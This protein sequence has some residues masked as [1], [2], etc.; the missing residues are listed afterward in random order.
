MYKVTSRI[1][2]ALRSPSGFRLEIRGGQGSSDRRWGMGNWGLPSSHPGDEEGMES[3]PS[4]QATASHRG[5][6]AG[7]GKS[8]QGTLKAIAF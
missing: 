5:G 8:V 1:V 6:R 4:A 7:V 3:Y 2:L